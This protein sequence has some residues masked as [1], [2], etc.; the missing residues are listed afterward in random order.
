MFLRI[1]L[2][3]VIW[4]R[5]LFTTIHNFVTKID[6]FVLLPHTHF[7]TI[8]ARFLRPI[9]ERI[10]NPSPRPPDVARISTPITDLFGIQHPVSCRAAVDDRHRGSQYFFQRTRSKP[11][12]GSQNVVLD[13]E[14]CYGRTVGFYDRNMGDSLCWTCNIH[15]PKVL[16]ER[17]TVHGARGAHFRAAELEVKFFVP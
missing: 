11:K 14:G 4:I 5:V 8:L 15:Q 7:G 9:F 13:D 1:L 2:L 6:S 10:E 3:V 16:Q 12:L 17:R